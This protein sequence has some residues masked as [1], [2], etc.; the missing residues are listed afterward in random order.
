MD[1]GNLPD[2]KLVWSAPEY[3]DKER[4]RDW[5]WAFG[6][7]VVT[8]MIA[9]II[10]GDYFFALLIVLAGVLLGI[11]AIKKSSIITYELNPKGLRIGSRLYPYENIRSFWVQANLS[12]G[13]KVK[14]LL[15]VHTER[16]FMP[17]LSIPIEEN[18]AEDIHDIFTAQEISEVEMKEHPSEKIMEILGF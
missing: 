13:T 6:V 12:P 1:K 15:F 16:V 14:P 4:S 7:V 11:F 9:A 3:E 10:L 2:Y 5:F 8:S 17:T 18:I